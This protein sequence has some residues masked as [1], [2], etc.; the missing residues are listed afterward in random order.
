MKRK[1]LWL[2]VALY[3]CFIWSNSFQNGEVSGGLSEQVTQILLSLLA[4]LGVTVG[5]FDLAHHAVRKLA[6]FS[7]FLLLGLLVCYAN[8]KQPL[9]PRNSQALA[10]FLA[11]PLL[12]EGL[13]LLVPGRAG[14]LTDVLIDTAGY[15]SGWL[16]S[17]LFRKNG[18]HL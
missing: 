11:V 13:Q 10:V 17:G 1:Y 6:H 16:I 4:R 15:L 2:I 3:V 7:E 9:F 5:D 12:D 14:V 18:G 8:R